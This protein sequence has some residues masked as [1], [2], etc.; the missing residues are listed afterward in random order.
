MIKNA[1]TIRA[2]KKNPLDL[3]FQSEK[4]TERGT[5]LVQRRNEIT[6]TRFPRDL[7]KIYNRPVRANPWTIPPV[8]LRAKP[9][10]THAIHT[11]L[12]GGGG[13]F[14]D[15]PATDRDSHE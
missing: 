2:L 10:P 7:R 5:R 6:W 3:I 8:G 11:H 13:E 4:K 1:A 9:R 15:E 14:I 12:F